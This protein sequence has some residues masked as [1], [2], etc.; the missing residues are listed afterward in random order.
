MK[1]GAGSQ[2]ATPH[3]HEHE[4]LVSEL[5]EADQCRE[6]TNIRSAPPNE[7]RL[8]RSLLAI[9]QETVL[10]RLFFEVSK[11]FIFQSETRLFEHSRRDALELYAHYSIRHERHPRQPAR[12]H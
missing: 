5:T 11:G 3:Q 9:Y 1:S 12:A 2:S 10:A 4:T 7:P 6:H 8:Y